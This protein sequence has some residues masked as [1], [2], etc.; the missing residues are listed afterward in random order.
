MTV[1][2]QQTVQPWLTHSG[3]QV[4]HIHRNI[5]IDLDEVVNIFGTKHLRRLELGN[6]LAY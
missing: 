4:I 2:N 1:E 5:P 6:V 3:S